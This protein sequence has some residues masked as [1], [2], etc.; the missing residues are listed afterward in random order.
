MKES[1]S[2]FTII[3]VLV[4][5]TVVGLLM[6]LLMPAI[7][8]ARESAR[9]TQCSSN[10]HQLGVAMHS[11]HDSHNRLPPGTVSHFSSAKQA[12]DVLISQSGYFDQ[13]N[14]TPET[15]WPLQLLSFLD[16]STLSDRFDSDYGTFGFVDLTPPFL[17]TGLNANSGVLAETQ[18]IFRCP[19]DESTAFS[20]DIDALLGSAIGIQPLSCTRGNYAANWGNTTW[21][22]SADINGDGQADFGVKFLNA[23]FTRNQCVRFARFTDGLDLTVVLGEVRQGN[24][25]DARGAMLTPLPGGSIYM[26]RFLPNGKRDTHGFVPMTGGGSGD[27]MP[28]PAT[29]TSSE[30]LPCSYNAV[31]HTSFAGSRSA[32]TGGVFVLTGGGRVRFMANETDESVWIA[33]HGIDEAEL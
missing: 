9:R 3:E 30:A 11:Y 28:F 27:Q 16:Q 24:G 6:A 21:E 8:A 33:M 15:P 1:R 32:H 14:A 10:L 4:S 23:P 17:L 12:F 25:I 31:A 18:P 7:H 19:S 29:C 26:S 5:L 2:G 13:E 22:Q 20:Y